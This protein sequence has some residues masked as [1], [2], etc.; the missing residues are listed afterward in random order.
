ML[1]YAEGMGV[2]EV[3]IDGTGGT[4]AAVRSRLVASGQWEGV[5]R[6]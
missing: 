5:W 3:E 6:V 1:I 2:E 4:V